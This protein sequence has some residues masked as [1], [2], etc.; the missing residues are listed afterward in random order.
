[1]TQSGYMGAWNSVGR[2]RMDTFVCMRICLYKEVQILIR[3]ISFQRSLQQIYYRYPELVFR[4][5][6]PS[7]IYRKISLPLGS[8]IRFLLHA[9]NPQPSFSIEINGLETEHLLV[10][11][12]PIQ[13]AQIPSSQM[14]IQCAFYLLLRTYYILRCIEL[15]APLPQRA[16]FA[17]AEYEL[18][19][20]ERPYNFVCVLADLTSFFST[21]LHTILNY[22]AVK[23]KN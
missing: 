9:P 13:G 2:S 6:N 12:L 16:R 1:M 5:C 22:I 14:R 11:N 15:L 7:V 3:Q 19:N 20:Q 10:W 23:S 18:S 21:T 4:S 8:F 17:T